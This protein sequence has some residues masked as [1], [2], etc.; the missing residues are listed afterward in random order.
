MDGVG[1][2]RPVVG[3]DLVR[4]PAAAEKG[5]HVVAD[6]KGVGDFTHIRRSS[7]MTRS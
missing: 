2:R 4:L 5:S 3:H 7:S 6:L 1:G